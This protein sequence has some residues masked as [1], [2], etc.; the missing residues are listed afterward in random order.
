[1]YF[2]IKTEKLLILGHRTGAHCEDCING[3]K[4]RLAFIDNDYF[5]Y[6]EVPFLRQV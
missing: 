1:M 5:I 2:K 6:T 4:I 3:G